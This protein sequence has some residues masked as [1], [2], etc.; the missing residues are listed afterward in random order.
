[1]PRESKPKAG[2]LPPAA[3]VRRKNTSDSPIGSGSL[4]LIPHKG[5]QAL[6]RR[7]GEV[8]SMLFRDSTMLILFI[9]K[10]MKKLTKRENSSVRRKLMM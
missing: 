1:M 7:W 3:A 10:Y 6:R 4:P 2:G 9:L 8:Y 5:A